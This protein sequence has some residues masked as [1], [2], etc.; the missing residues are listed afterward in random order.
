MGKEILMVVDAMSNERGVEKVVI[1]E[2]IEEAIAS[3][4][5]RGPEEDNEGEARV[6]VI[7]D[8]ETGDYETFRFWTVVESADFMNAA[9]EMCVD[10]LEEAYKDLSAGDEVKEQIES[11]EFGRIAAQQARQVIFQKI[12]EAEREKTAEKYADKIGELLIASVK[13][14]NREGVTLELSDGA[15]AALLPEDM[16]PRERFRMND[17]V[18]VYLKGISDERRGPQLLVS[19]TCPEMLVELFKIEVPEISEDV[20]QIIAA[21]RDPGSRAKIAIKT[22]DGRIDPKGACIGMRGARV[23]AVSNE[24]GGERID[25]I[26]WEDDPAKLVMNAMAPA[27]VESLVIDED[28]HSMDIAVSEGNLSQAIGRSG[29]NVR[30]A[31]ELTGWELNVMGSDDLA[32]KYDN[33]MEDVKK[34]FQDALDVDEDVAILLAQEG[35]TTVAEIADVASDELAAIDGFDGDIVDVLQ[36]R[37]S[38]YLLTQEIADEEEALGGSAQDDLSSVDG[39]TPEII[40]QLLAAKV[41]TRDDLA[42][43]AVDELQEIIEVDDEAAA[44]L[45]MA[46]RAH[47]FSEEKNDNQ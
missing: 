7:I 41:K 27:E 8:R 37:A 17:R 10:E 31:S 19:R 14:V 11:P 42:E 23:Q 40:A 18:R 39:I 6:E 4:A 13:R 3:I 43:F 9:A 20:I 1:F 33:E 45:I 29:Q 47:W 28:K 16:I 24:L 44:K 22:N 35:F 34:V 46:A 26:L 30:L 15:E 12:R 25:I 32:T 38:D 5:A 36:M 21:A 2:A